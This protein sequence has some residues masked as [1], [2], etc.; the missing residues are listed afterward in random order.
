MNTESVVRAM[1]ENI[2]NIKAEN[3]PSVVPVIHFVKY[4]RLHSFFSK[5]QNSKVTFL[6]SLTMEI[7]LMVD[8]E[9]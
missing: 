1:I 3:T 7:F 5:A 9:N 8:I 6:R 2:G 4:N